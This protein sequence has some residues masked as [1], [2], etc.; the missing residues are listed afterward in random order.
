MSVERSLPY[1]MN[2]ALNI[3]EFQMKVITIDSARLREKCTIT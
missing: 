1:G 2:K 3:W